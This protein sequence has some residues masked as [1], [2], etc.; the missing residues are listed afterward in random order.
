MV[1]QSVDGDRFEIV[2]LRDTGDV[3]PHRRLQVF[4]N[5]FAANFRCPYEMDDVAY[6][7]M[8]HVFI[9]PR[10]GLGILYG[11]FPAL[12]R[13]AFTFGAPRLWFWP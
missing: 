13:G 1:V 12:K 10:R 7:C 2:V 9:R 6:Q 3:R 4:S 5:R 11:A 8:C